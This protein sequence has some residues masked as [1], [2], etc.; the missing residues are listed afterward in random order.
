MKPVEDVL[1]EWARFWRIEYSSEP[2]EGIEYYLK[3]YCDLLKETRTERLIKI[4][5]EVR[6]EI[7]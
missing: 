3:Q 2:V 7:K 5:R 1:H 6:G 4:L